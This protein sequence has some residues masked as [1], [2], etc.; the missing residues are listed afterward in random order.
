M[1]EHAEREV[2]AC[3]VAADD[4]V[5][6]VFAEVLQRVAEEFDALRQLPWV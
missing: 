4:D 3:R 2:A 1:R 6:G 5:R